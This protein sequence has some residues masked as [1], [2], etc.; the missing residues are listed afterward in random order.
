MTLCP[1][2]IAVGCK[3]CPVI[4]V[5]PLKGIIGDYKEDKPDQTPKEKKMTTPRTKEKK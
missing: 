2:A 5:C 1:V 3:R 4:S